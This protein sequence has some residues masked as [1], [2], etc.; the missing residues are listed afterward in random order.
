MSPPF[1]CPLG[2]R[3]CLTEINQK[4]NEPD[5]VIAVIPLAQ[6]SDLDPI[7]ETSLGA[8]DRDCHYNLK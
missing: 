2:T 4:P 6:S 5:R 1:Q 8:Y 3:A 7:Y